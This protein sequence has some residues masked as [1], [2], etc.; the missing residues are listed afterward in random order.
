MIFKI[1]KNRFRKDMNFR[2]Q[3]S[4]LKCNIIKV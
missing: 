1:E 2:S 4:D 3:F